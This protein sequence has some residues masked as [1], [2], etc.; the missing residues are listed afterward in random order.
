M[1]LVLKN[2]TDTIPG[3][4]PFC[5]TSSDLLEQSK[6]LELNISMAQPDSILKLNNCFGVVDLE[7]WK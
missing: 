1:V 4:L 5:Q 3:C 2:K 7:P 6:V